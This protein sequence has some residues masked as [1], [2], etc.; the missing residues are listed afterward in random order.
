MFGNSWDQVCLR[1]NV[2]IPLFTT[3]S[4]WDVMRASAAKQM[5]NGSNMKIKSQIHKYKIKEKTC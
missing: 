2:R 1:C 5:N 4:S 3:N